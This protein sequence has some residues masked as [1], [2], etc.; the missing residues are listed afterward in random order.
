MP[1]TKSIGLFLLEKWFKTTKTAENGK[2]TS[3]L[4]HKSGRVLLVLVCGPKRASFL[5]SASK[6]RS[7]MALEEAFPD[8]PL[9]ITLPYSYTPDGH[10]R[11]YGQYG[12]ARSYS[13]SAEQR[14][15]VR[16]FA[17]H[18]SGLER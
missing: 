10:V 6:Y 18:S 12:T 16:H 13:R 5:D 7:G 2:N 1:H 8:L 17:V 11:S 4:A 3:F 9:F 15:I 14:N